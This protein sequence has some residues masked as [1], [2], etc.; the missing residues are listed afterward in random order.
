[1]AAFLERANDESLGGLTVAI[2]LEPSTIYD[3][4][5]GM[6]ANWS[7]VSSVLTLKARAED[8]LDFTS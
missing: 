7:P 4:G 6:A 2:R 8:F 1:M 3:L 5:Y